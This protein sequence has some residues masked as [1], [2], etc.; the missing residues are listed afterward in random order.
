MKEFFKELCHKYWSDKRLAMATLL[1]LGALTV[2]EILV[3]RLGIPTP[4]THDYFYAPIAVGALVG[5]YLTKGS[6]SKVILAISAL[7]FV[8]ATTT[9][10]YCAWVFNEITFLKLLSLV[11]L[12]F[13]GIGGLFAAL[14]ILLNLGLE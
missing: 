9:H 7:I 6:H 10:R 12:G 1:F 14:R 3:W 5:Y 2:V 11:L 8:L 13:L 4:I